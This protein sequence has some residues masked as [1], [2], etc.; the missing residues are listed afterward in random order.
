MASRRLRD[1]QQHRHAR[2]FLSRSEVAAK[3]SELADR[4]EPLRD[5]FGAI[6]EPFP[7]YTMS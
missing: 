3:L 6:I 7:E 5:S 2:V 1:V 4:V